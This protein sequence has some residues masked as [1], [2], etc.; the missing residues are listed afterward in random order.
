MSLI[1]FLDA[2]LTLLAAEILA[3]IEKVQLLRPP[4]RIE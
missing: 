2:A 4:W 3:K 1:A